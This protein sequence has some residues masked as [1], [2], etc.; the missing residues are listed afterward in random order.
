MIGPVLHYWYGL[1][2]RLVSGT[3]TVGALGRLV[4]LISA[5]HSMLCIC[6]STVPATANAAT[7]A[8]LCGGLLA[9]LM[10]RLCSHLCCSC[11][12]AMDQ[13]L[14]APPFVAANFAVLK[15]LEVGL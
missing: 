14:F 8:G 1:N 4:R 3:G 9:S 7:S 13:L 10:R 12:Q 15:L 6:C 2:A 11:D 5:R